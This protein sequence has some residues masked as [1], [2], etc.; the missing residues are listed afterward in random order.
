MINLISADLYKIRKSMAIKILFGITVISSITMTVM[1]YMIQYGKL[2]TGST[3]IGFMF[4]DANIIAILGAVIAGVFICGDF[5]NRIIHESIVNGKSRGQVVVCKTVVFGCALIFILVPYALAACIALS[6]GYKFS[7]GAASAGFL[8]IITTL[9]GTEI[10]GIGIWKLVIVI[11]AFFILY[12]AQL[13]LCI[14]LAII[15]KKPVIVV[16]VYYGI[17]ILI[18]QLTTLSYRS[19]AFKNIFACTPYGGDYLLLTVNSSAQDIIKVVCVS[20]VYIVIMVSVT[21]D[22]FRKSEIK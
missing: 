11:L 4:S 20:L 9:G 22:A 7:M 16:A 8:H 1:A 5:D 17:T 2:N 13:S 3:G 14:P 18:P 15:S 21:F 19:K 6:T 10:S 12:V